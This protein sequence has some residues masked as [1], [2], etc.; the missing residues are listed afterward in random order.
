LLGRLG[1]ETLAARPAA[2]G[3]N[4]AAAHRRHPRPKAV[5]ALADEVARLA[6]ALHRSF[7]QNLKKKGRR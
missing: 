1:R 4:L 7:S 2:A 6:G 5:T 3:D